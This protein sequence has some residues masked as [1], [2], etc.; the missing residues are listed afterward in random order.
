MI[1]KIKDIE[2]GV[3]FGIGFVRKLDE[4]YYVQN[5][6]SVKFGLGVETQVPKLLTGDPVALSEFLYLGTC[7]EEKRPSQADVDEYLDDAENIDVLFDEVIEEL[8]RSNATRAKL[9]ELEANLKEEEEKEK[10]RKEAEKA[11]R[12]IPKK[13][14]K[15]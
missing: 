1:L 2:Y 12:E 8:R 11:G 9:G 15:R 13:S 10:A 3:K 4:K 5:N 6:T 7:A 14:M